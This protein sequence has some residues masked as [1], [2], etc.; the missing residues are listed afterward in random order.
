MI[1]VL[2]RRDFEQ[3]KYEMLQLQYVDLGDGS[4]PTVLG[5]TD[6]STHIQYISD[7]LG[8]NQRTVQSKEDCTICSPVIVF[9]YS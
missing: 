8:T 4:D 7:L 1:H 9:Y 2:P 3:M 6:E 5:T